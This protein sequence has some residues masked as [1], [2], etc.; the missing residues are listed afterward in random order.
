MEEPPF[1][2]S[3]DEFVFD[4]RQREI[5]EL[6]KLIGPEPTQFFTDACRIVDG[7]AG[8]AMQTHFAAHS[9]REDRGTAARRV[10][11]DALARGEGEDR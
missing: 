11:P 2:E 3:R 1:R 10:P 9:L 4:P 5:R 6:L 8:V 7:A